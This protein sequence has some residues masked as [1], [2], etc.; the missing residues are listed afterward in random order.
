MVDSRAV[1][2]GRAIRR[3]REC[4]SCGQRFTTFERLEEVA[5]VVEK[6]SGD[7]VPFDREKIT[8]GIRA[9]CK[10][11]PVDDRAIGELATGIEDRARAEGHDVILSERIGREVLEGLRELDQI[12]YLRFA[13]VYKVFED[14]ADFTREVG[15][16]TKHSEPKRH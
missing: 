7:R 1:D 15:L 2:H 10:N 6:R 9:A 8:A 12:A 4:L 5:L 11:R 14:P 13:S 3:R 16:L